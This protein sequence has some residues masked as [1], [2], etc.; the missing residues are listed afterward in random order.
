MVSRCCCC[1]ACRARDARA[2]RAI[3]EANY[4]DDDAARIAAD[5]E[6]AAAERTG[7]RVRRAIARYG[8]TD[9]RG[10]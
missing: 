6:Q 9:E 1:V 4:T 10:R 5:L 7:A 3:I 8:I 2:F